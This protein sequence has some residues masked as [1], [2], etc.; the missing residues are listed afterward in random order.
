PSPRRGGRGLDDR[1]RVAAV[2]PVA[3]HRV[4]P[5][6]LA[7]RALRDRRP[8]EDRVN[9]LGKPALRVRIV[10]R[11]H[12]GVL[13]DGLDGLAQGQLA[14]VQL[15]ALEVLRPANVLARLA[16]EPRQRVLA[17]LGLLVEARGPERE[18]PVA[19]LERRQA[20]ARMAIEDTG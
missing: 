2:A 14:L 9:R 5:E 17:H 10:R 11:E 12:Q 20:Q 7:P 6:E 16:L 3:A 19:A 15:D 13:A 1:R 4:L 18:P 8:L